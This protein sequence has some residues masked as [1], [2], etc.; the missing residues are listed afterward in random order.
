ML[1]NLEQESPQFHYSFTF[2]G[3]EEY[4]GTRWVKTYYNEALPGG[5]TENNVTTDDDEKRK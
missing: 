1:I 3:F 2:N 5:A 4:K